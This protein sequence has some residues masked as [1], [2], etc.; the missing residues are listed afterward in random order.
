[1][2]T[3][4]NHQSSAYTKM[5]YIGDSSTGKTGSLVSLLLAGYNLRILDMDNGLDS[6]VAFGR[7]AGADLSKVEY[8][9]I[10]DQYRSTKAGPMARGKTQA[11]KEALA[12][13]TA[14]ETNDEPKTLFDI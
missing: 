13:R 3:L 1:M 7:E 6:L 12:K 9:T 8:E 11:I 2:A 14:R 4:D 5:V 10:R